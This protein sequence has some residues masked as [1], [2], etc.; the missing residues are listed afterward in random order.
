MLRIPRQ[1]VTEEEKS[2]K[3]KDGIRDGEGELGKWTVTEQRCKEIKE[4]T[5]QSG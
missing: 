2:D 4:T 5:K 3:K 1:V